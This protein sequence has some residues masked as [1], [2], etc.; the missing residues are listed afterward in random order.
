[1]SDA[2]DRP[3]SARA[4]SVS[5]DLLASG[6]EDLRIAEDFRPV[7]ARAIEVLSREYFVRGEIRIRL[8]RDEEMS[9]LHERHT[10]IAGTTDVLT[11][12]LRDTPLDQTSPLDADLVL[13]IDEAARQ[14][15]LRSIHIVHELVL[16]AVH[17]ILHMLGHDDH[18]ND[19]YVAMHEVEDRVLAAAGIGPVFSA[20]LAKEQEP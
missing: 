20:P 4:G 14:A 3:P 8:V 16:Y 13:C 1:M 11:F 7:L 18:D 9:M 2:D 6:A 17:G 15:Q 10:G 19:A 12:D 5:V